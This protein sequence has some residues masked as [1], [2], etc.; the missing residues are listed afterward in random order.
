MSQGGEGAQDVRT[1]VSQILRDGIQ[2][3]ADAIAKIGLK[4]GV[5]VVVFEPKEPWIEVLQAWEWKSRLVFK[6]PRRAYRGLAT[7]PVTERWLNRK[8]DGKTTRI[9]LVVHFGSLLINFEPGR[10][11][12]REPGSSDA[13]TF[14][15]QVH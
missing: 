6:L 3:H 1:L 13:E 4:G 5:V 10:G 9:F 2:P 8:F 15:P 7:D 12:W 14:P 11:Y